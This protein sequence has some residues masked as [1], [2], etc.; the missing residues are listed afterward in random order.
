MA[1][2]EIDALGVFEKDEET[3][4]VFVLRRTFHR[5]NPS[6]YPDKKETEVRTSTFL[7]LEELLVCYRRERGNWYFS[8]FEWFLGVLSKQSLEVLDEMIR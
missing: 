3:M 1:L 7:T 4:R 8:G 2:K 6:A 5:I